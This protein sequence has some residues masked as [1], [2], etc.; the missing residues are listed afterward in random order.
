MEFS[1]L[2]ECRQW[3]TDQGLTVTGY[4]SETGRVYQVTNFRGGRCFYGTRQQLIDD[5][6]AGWLR[7]A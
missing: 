7:Y 6:N 2:K 3:L 5:L 4:Q 1:N